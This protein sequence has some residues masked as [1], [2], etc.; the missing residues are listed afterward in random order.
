MPVLKE[1]PSDAELVS[2]RL[3]LR[4]GMIRQLSSGIYSWLPL[5]LKVLQKV[6]A[7]IQDEMNT[8]DAVEMM[9]PVVQPSELWCESGRWHDYGPELL[10]FE[11]RHENSFCLGPTHEEI[12]TSIM[13]KDLNSYKML[14]LTVYQ[15]QTKFRDEIRPRFGIMR[16]R[17]FL[18]KDAYS[19]HLS[20]ESMQDTYDVMYN[21]Y[22]TILTKLD[23]SFRAVAADSGAIGGQVSHEFQVLAESGEDCVVYSDEGEYAANIELAISLDPVSQSDAKL[24][25]VSTISAGKVNIDSNQAVKTIVVQGK[26]HNK[27]ALVVRCDHEINEVKLSHI[28]AV[29][30]PLKVMAVEHDAHCLLKLDMPLIVDK[31]AAALVNFSCK[32]SGIDEHYINVNW[33][34][35][36]KLGEV[37]D[38]RNVVEGDS[39]PDGCGIL[40]FARGIEVGHIF[41]LGDK[42]SKTMNANV[43]DANGKNSCLLMG[44]YGLG[45][46][47]I[48]AAAI[49]QHHDDRGIVWPKALA[50]FQVILVPVQMHKS[51]RVK[52]CVEGL[53][54]QFKDMGVDVLLDDRKERPGVMF[55]TADLIGIPHRIVV[56]ER[57]IDDGVVEYKSRRASDP[58]SWQL[59]AINELLIDVL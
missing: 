39:S 8:A 41:Q 59:S 18:M 35:D 17:E 34:R 21:A 15:I 32:S 42:Y 58:V 6:S 47:R 36:V 2:H 43:L 16:S 49:E 29:S 44:C 20:Q 31:S 7:I 23:L 54:Q 45:V 37:V 33:G 56:S 10:R 50:P 19:F 24:L 3:M 40:K 51:Y 57:G 53:Y 13:K 46:S 27:I 55:A 11:D 28:D 12:I 48:V 9:M 4:A 26:D 14:P 5:G 38:I 30:M 1:T 25:P 22:C 52:E